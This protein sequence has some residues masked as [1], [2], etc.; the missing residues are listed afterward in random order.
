MAGYRKLTGA[1]EEWA[2]R[3]PQCRDQPRLNSD[4][5]ARSVSAP[6]CSTM[7]CSGSDMNH[8]K[9]RHPSVGEGMISSES[10]VRETRTHGSMSGDWKPDQGS[11]TEA[12]SESDGTATGPYRR[13]ASPRLYRNKAIQCCRCKILHSPADFLKRDDIGLTAVQPVDQVRQSLAHTIDRPSCYSHRIHKLRS[14]CANADIAF[15]IHGYLVV[16]PST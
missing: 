2:G 11:R 13:C 9:D 14:F 7:M 1:G 5:S 4:G 16:T 3:V 12:R 15:S 6:R 8:A 10:R